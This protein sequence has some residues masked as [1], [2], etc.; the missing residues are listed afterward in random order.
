VIARAEPCRCGQ[1]SVMLKLGWRPTG[2]GDVVLVA[3]CAACLTPQVIDVMVDASVCS[4]CHRVVSGEPDDPKACFDRDGGS[5]VLCF[6][7][8]RRR[9]PIAGPHLQRWGVGR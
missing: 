4:E 3:R 2:T 1:M 5:Q 7:C 9:H 8:A 6:A